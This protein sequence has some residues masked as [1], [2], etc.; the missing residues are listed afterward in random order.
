MIRDSVGVSEALRRPML[1]AQRNLF[2]LIVLKD[3]TGNSSPSR[4]NQIQTAA[5]E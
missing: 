3:H 2:F 5:A 1:P 4:Y